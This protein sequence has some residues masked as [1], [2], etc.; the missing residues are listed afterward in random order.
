MSFL[1]PLFLLGGLAVA[2]PVVFH[3]IR[4]SSKEQM[5]FSSLMFLKPVL[6]RVTKRSRLE[7]VFLLLL[8]C[9][10]ICL[11]ALGFARPFVQQPLAADPAADTG[12]KLI[13]LVDT[14]ASMKREG[15]WAAAVE[16]AK[17]AVKQ[18]EP[19]DQ[20]AVM[21][22]DTRPRTLISFAQWA[23]MGADERAAVTATRL[24]AVQPTWYAT[25]LGNALIAA[26]EAFA[27]ADQQGQNIGRRQIVL[28]SD[29]HEGSRLD[30]LQGYDWPRG[31]EVQVE[32]IEP[33]HPTNAGLQW[34]VEN[35]EAARAATNPLPRIRVSNSSDSR[36][37]QFQIHWDGVS[38][39]APL[40]VYVPPGQSRIVNAPA[41]PTNVTGDR[42]VLTG[43]DEDFDNSVYV[44]APGV[45]HVNLL[46]LGDELENDP[47]RPLYYL[48][49][50]FQETPG[51]VVDLKTRAPGVTLGPTDLA[52]T[53]LLISMERLSE[54]QLASAQDFMNGGGTVLLVMTNSA[55]AADVGRLA[56]VGALTAEEAAPAN[57]A[58]LGSVDFSHPLFAP[59]ADA[60]YNDFTKI[61][62]W[63]YRRLDA[64]KLTG[65][66]VPAK[67]DNGDPLCLEIPRGKG[68]LLVLTSGWQPADSQ[69]ALSSKFVPL[70]Y[71]LLDLSGGVK[72]PL[73]QFRV[74]DE[75]NLAGY[76]PA[77][78][79]A[80]PIAIRKPDGTEV[81][82]AAGENRF[83]QT[84]TPGLYT[85]T[86]T[87]P[88]ARFVVNLDGA[89]SRTA[90]LPADE[91]QRLGVPMKAR[92][93]PRTAQVAQKRRLHEAELE[94]QQK[95]WRWLT[96]AALVLLIAETWVAGWLTSRAVSRT[97]VTI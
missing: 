71:S 3:L 84:D 77:A 2:L 59:F 26:A 55:A 69:L 91:L 85:I 67:F 13:V 96:L 62:F 95:L 44:L 43:D 83:A 28:I 88:A 33:K 52:D 27:D 72:A 51:Q 53:R 31:V 76:L 80:Q 49:R 14:S 30:G 16:R 64:A 17:A 23:A 46:V 5:P 35:D 10:V 90:A 68:R 39:A 57:Y 54:N 78:D 12:R 22:F 74:G 20:V 34:I 36:R 37:E 58:L 38:G 50:A 81:R 82:L 41:L 87:L 75:V 29:M 15:V 8:R 4:R 32:T 21:T 25:Q 40:D 97:E 70:L 19:G 18:A 6:P 45:E 94:R 48:K 89:E 63:K 47:G 1:A 86:T 9:L 61:H 60:R 93:I 42:I 11:L 79:L 65:A 73:T 24:A 7:N 92:E 56:G 66:R